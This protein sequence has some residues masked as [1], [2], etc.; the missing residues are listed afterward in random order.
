MSATAA[1]N[2]RGFLEQGSSRPGS[3]QQNLER[4]L[5]CGGLPSPANYRRLTGK[6]FNT[7]KPNSMSTDLCSHLYLPSLSCSRRSW[8]LPGAS[9]NPSHCS[10]MWA[11]IVAF[12]ATGVRSLYRVAAVAFWA[13]ASLVGGASCVCPTSEPNPPVRGLLLLGLRMRS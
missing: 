12:R 13:G 2:G 1:P 9:L 3:L 7:G 11:P 5:V 6:G 8:F 10:V 4:G